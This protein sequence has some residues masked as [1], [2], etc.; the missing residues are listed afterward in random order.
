[1]PST[2]KE[3]REYF[4]SKS[5]E[6]QNQRLSQVKRIQLLMANYKIP[7]KIGL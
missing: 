1:M 5:K 3:E 6:K 7:K 2:I 4:V